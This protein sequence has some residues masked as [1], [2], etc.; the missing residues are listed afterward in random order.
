M[1]GSNDLIEKY[2]EQAIKTMSRGELIIKLYDEMIKNLKYASTLFQQKNIPAA[3]KCTTKCRDILNYLLVILD[4]KYNLSDTLG[5]LYSYMLGQIVLTNATGD[6][7]HIDGIVPK[8]Q[9]LREAWVEAEKNIR[10]Q[11]GATPKPQEHKT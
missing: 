4:H 6:P 9:E 8:L 5:K 11:G 2:Q 3:K 10:A 7:S 1:Y